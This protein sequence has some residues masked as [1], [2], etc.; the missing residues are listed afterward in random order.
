MSFLTEYCVSAL[1]YASIGQ[2]SVELIIVWITLI[3][4]CSVLK[5]FLNCGCG[6]FIF[7]HKS[8]TVINIELSCTKRN[9]YYGLF[10]FTITSDVLHYTCGKGF[11]KIMNG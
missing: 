10:T 7:A 11:I 6:P 3:I 1:M 2:E 5:M 9:V 8:T 4:I